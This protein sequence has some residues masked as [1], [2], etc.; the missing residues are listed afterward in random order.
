MGYAKIPINIVTGSSPKTF[1][2][3]KMFVILE[4]NCSFE[5]ILKAITNQVCFA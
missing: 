2:M 3:L 4:D 5:E 1:Y